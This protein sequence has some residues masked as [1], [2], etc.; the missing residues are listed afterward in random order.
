MLPGCFHVQLNGS[1]DDSELTIT[2][3]RDQNNVLDTGTSLGANDWLAVIEQQQW[4]EWGPTL[5]LY[6]LGIS[7]MP[8]KGYDANTLYLVTAQGGYDYDRNRD[9]LIDDTG[10]LVLG[11][12][13]AI[14]PGERLKPGDIKV[15]A[16]TE[17]AY[18]VMESYLSG[19]SDAQVI[20]QL[21][22][23]ATFMV[24]DLDESGAVNYSDLLAWSRLTNASQY[25]GD[26]ATVNAF[27]EA[28]ADGE[29][30]TYRAALADAIVAAGTS[31]SIATGE[32]TSS[33]GSDDPTASGNQVHAI[34]VDTAQEVNLSLASRVDTVL[35]LYDSN[36]QLLASN[37][38]DVDSNSRISGTLSAGNYELIAATY[39][40]GDSDD[41]VLRLQGATLT[42]YVPKNDTEQ[43]ISIQ[44][45][46]ANVSNSSWVNI[47]AAYKQV[48][49]T[50]LQTVVAMSSLAFIDPDK[51][52][53]EDFQKRY[54]AVETALD[55]MAA[56]GATLEAIV[57]PFETE[58][59]TTGAARSLTRTLGGE[60]GSASA[61]GVVA[62]ENTIAVIKRL[63][64]IARENPAKADQARRALVKLGAI[65]KAE[66]EAAK[67]EGEMH[68]KLYNLAS[69]VKATAKMSVIGIGFV[70]SGGGAGVVA[71]IGAVATVVGAS[72][73]LFS[74]ANE[75][76]DIHF[77]SVGVELKFPAPVSAVSTV[78]GMITSPLNQLPANII[79]N[80]DDLSNYGSKI[81]N[82]VI[83]S[84][85]K[86]IDVGEGATVTNSSEHGKPTMPPVV[87]GNYLK[88]PGDASQ[89]VTVTEPEDFTQDILDAL[90]E[91]LDSDYEAGL[92][93]IVFVDPDTNDDGESGNDD[94]NYDYHPWVQCIDY[95]Y[96]PTEGWDDEYYYCV[97]YGKDLSAYD[98]AEQLLEAGDSGTVDADG[99][100]CRANG[101]DSVYSTIY[102]YS[103]D[104]GFSGTYRA[105]C[106]RECGYK[107]GED[108]YYCGG[109]IE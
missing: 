12:I 89:P 45:S 40:S 20:A 107:T 4:D 14:V 39:Y 57:S 82:L 63:G 9:M 60:V 32:W 108:G 13:R 8:T 23:F 2:P 41:Y 61:A 44:T 90:D 33:G 17:A 78:V 52:N 62:G 11:A 80:L 85:K 50:Y 81:V 65:S 31:P 38:D 27:S 92:D 42:N 53:F 34:T 103:V 15:S 104:Q 86:T 19:L 22:E 59:E 75:Q 54:Q 84:E 95:R 7:N 106:E 18:T 46:D 43:T 1:I 72:D 29:S 47:N 68:N 96:N 98:A 26:L 69:T 66:Y 48:H 5:Q 99:N 77:G 6:L 21:N 64:R 74:Y 49:L 25:K 83:D 105:A 51:T 55:A 36:G 67:A 109:T 58:I 10:D 88:E 35:F 79:A 70:A 87:A 71:N 30:A 16:L 91:D 97:L 93:D 100:F 24:P 28:I 101:M 73:V 3:L 76:Q 94:A 102:A 56:T 37:D